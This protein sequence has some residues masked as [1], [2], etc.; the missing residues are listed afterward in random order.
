MTDLFFHN[1]EIIIF[2]LKLVFNGRRRY[3][4]SQT[5]PVFNDSGKERIKL[6]TVHG[7]NVHCHKRNA[8]FG[9]QS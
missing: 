4:H 7:H 1:P 9:L 2:L 5:D 6:S 8:L 3:N